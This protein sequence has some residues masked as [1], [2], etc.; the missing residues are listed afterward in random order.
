MA[1]KKDISDLRAS[2]AIKVYQIIK[3]KVAVVKYHDP[4]VSQLLM[5]RKIIRS[6]KLTS[7]E[8][9]KYDVVMI[10]T[11]HTLFDYDF[12]VKH[13]KLVIDTRNAIRKKHKKIR[14]L[15]VL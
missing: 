13:A 1:F 4:H 14:K 9:K 8:L 3:P 11:D 10:L 15:G 5:N 2:P 6:V 12:I 7:S